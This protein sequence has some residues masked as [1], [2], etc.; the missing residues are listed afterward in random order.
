MPIHCLITGSTGFIGSAVVKEMLARGAQVTV[1]LRPESDT[2]R[3]NTLTGYEQLVVSDLRSSDLIG[4]LK[5]IKPDALIHCGW[6]GVGGHDR[7]EAFQISENLQLTLDTVDLAA[8]SG[9]SQ[10]IGFGSQAEYGNLN[11]RI[12]EEAAVRPTTLYGKAKLAAG[13]AALALC[14]ARGLEG[15]WM[16]VFSTYGPGDSP[17]W[18]LPY[19][20]LEFLAGRNPE[21]TECE[22]KWDYL[23]VDDAAKAVAETLENSLQGIFNLGSGSAHPLKEYIEAIRKELGIDTEPLY[24]AKP[25]REDQVMHLEADISKLTEATNWC[26]EVSIEEG[27]RELVAYERV[28]SE[29]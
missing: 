15:A 1:I 2:S 23:Y 10:W 6:R 16:R 18:F 3:L 8:A 5:K 28:R 22:Q 24:G 13:I 19:V 29:Q 12:S 9:C 14:E 17:R 21:I 25:Y 11:C 27:I 4:K 7:N 26:P 20:I